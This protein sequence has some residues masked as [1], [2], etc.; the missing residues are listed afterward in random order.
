MTMHDF[1][2][3]SLQHAADTSY[4]V[5]QGMN[6]GFQF[7][8]LLAPPLYTAFVIAR[9]GRSAWTLNQFLRMTWVGGLV[10]AGAFG[11]A[12]YVR[13]ANSSFETTRT[14][15][16]KAEYD[17]SRIRR[18]DHSTIGAVVAAV[19]TPAILWKRANPVNLIMGGAGIGSGIGVLTHY[20]RSL[21]GDVPAKINITPDTREIS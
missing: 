11:G 20:G 5:R 8:S 13:Y 16:I 17:T 12:N 15:R 7:M 21:S 14:N 10:G 2:D 18:E 3:E 4:L 19:L 1:T 9:K 6:T